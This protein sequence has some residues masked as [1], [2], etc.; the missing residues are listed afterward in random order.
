MSATGCDRGL[1]SEVA[2][3]VSSLRKDFRSAPAL[4]M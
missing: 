3:K 4:C 1:H 2:P